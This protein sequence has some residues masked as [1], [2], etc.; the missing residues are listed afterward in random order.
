MEAIKKLIEL[1][2]NKSLKKR[3]EFQRAR[4]EEEILKKSWD[5]G[6]GGEFE[7]EEF[8]LNNAQQWT[9]FNFPFRDRK[10]NLTSTQYQLK[11]V[12]NFP[13]VA[14]YAQS[15]ALTPLSDID[16]EKYIE[17]VN[18][19]YTHLLYKSN[20]AILENKDISI[21]PCQVRSQCV[22]KCGIH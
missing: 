7:V 17:Y 6:G 15:M 1:V 2:W 12:G 18:N 16:G 10:K 19:A 22:Q 8:M 9:F 20:Y 5:G 11:Y 14:L 21:S 3:V 13:N 4:G